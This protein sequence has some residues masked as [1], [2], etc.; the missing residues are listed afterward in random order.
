MV[1]LA[2][3][4]LLGKLGKAKLL[5][6]GAIA[7]EYRTKEAKSSQLGQVEWPL[8]AGVWSED[9]LAEAWLASAEPT[10]GPQDEAGKVKARLLSSKVLADECGKMVET[11]G[12]LAGRSLN[13]KAEQPAKVEAVEEPLPELKGKTAAPK[14]V[15]EDE[16]RIWSGSEGE[17][18]DSE[19]DQSELE[20]DSDSDDDGA[21]ENL[22]EDA[23]QAKLA[24]LGDL[25]KWDAL[26]AAGSDEDADDG[27]DADQQ[28]AGPS[29]SSKRKRS[30]SPRPAVAKKRQAAQVAEPSSSEGEDV[31]SEEDSEADSDDDDGESNSS[32]GLPAL[33]HGFLAQR[34][35]TKDDDFSGSESG[36]DDD[37]PIDDQAEDKAA[38]A[39][40]GSKVSKERK[41]RM[42]QRARKALWEKKYGRNA[43]HVK[44]QQ[45]DKKPRPEASEGRPAFK[46]LRRGRDG[47]AL[48]D[49]EAPKEVDSGWKK[50][51][52]AA[53]PADITRSASGTKGKRPD[54]SAPP[55]KALQPQ[56]NTYV[57]KGDY[58]M[59]SNGASSAGSGPSRG[60]ATP[61]APQQEMHPSWVAKQKQKEKEEMIARSLAGGGGAGKKVTFD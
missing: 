49:F 41:N 55:R 35:R 12:R 26:V 46:P 21:V 24:E 61:A 54:A 4:A 50:F 18:S 38:K 60:K 42:G 40:K 11:L 16:E 52:V 45:K 20:E 28:Q 56:Q 37:D 30:P 10:T 59:D 44:L 43:N 25:D 29:T 34:L 48:P 33:S 47:K 23:I 19:D 27:S 9:P 31:D 58:R 39:A 8:L 36:S 15:D 17:S 1:G 53:T 7:K 51:P 2:S 5:P 57:P 13:G 3:T 6:R 32:Y 14:K 22:D